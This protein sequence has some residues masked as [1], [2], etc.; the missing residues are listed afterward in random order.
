MPKRVANAQLLFEI[1]ATQAGYFTAQQ[2]SAASYSRR[3]LAYHA[4]TGRFERVSR[5]FYR[6]REFPA[7]SHEDIVAAWVKSGP[8]K[9]VVSHETALALHDLSTA[10]PRKI[11]ITLPREARPAGNRP[12]LS[13]VRIHTTTRSFRPGE[14]VHR[15]GVR[16]TSPVRTIVDAAEAGT[17]PEHIIE[18]VAQALA[19]RLLTEKELRDAAAGR[20]GRVQR[21]VLRA[22]QEARQYAP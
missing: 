12:Q 6:I 19:R 2:A 7:L 18:A 15:E 11:D 3:N 5:G 16:M 9:A 17:G 22:L 14:V 4:S 1:A 21:L 13:A 10:R 20:S 8:S